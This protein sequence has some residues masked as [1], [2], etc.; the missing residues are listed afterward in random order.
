MLLTDNL[1]NNISVVDTTRMLGWTR[2]F[3]LVAKHSYWLNKVVSLLLPASQP[4]EKRGF[5]VFP[6][7]P[8]FKVQIITCSVPGSNLHPSLLMR[9]TDGCHLKDVIF[10]IIT[11]FKGVTC[12]K[13]L[14]GFTCDERYSQAF[15]FVMRMGHNLP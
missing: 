3:Y 10:F 11:S 2:H 1:L 15:M 12:V 13:G 14:W 5:W 6:P 9:F 4:G 7:K 8:A